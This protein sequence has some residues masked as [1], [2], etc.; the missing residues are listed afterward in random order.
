MKSS[1]EILKKAEVIKD[2]IIELRRQ[3]HRYP[4]LAY[5]EFRTSELI[6]KT[7]EKLEIPYQAG[8]ADA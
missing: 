7:L 2:W 3:L 4:E 5:Q 8:V 1:K 6:C